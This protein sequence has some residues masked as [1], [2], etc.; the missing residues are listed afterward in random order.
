MTTIPRTHQVRSFILARRKYLTSR[1]DV[2]SADQEEDS[3][4]VTAKLAPSVLQFI[5]YHPGC[6]LTKERERYNAVQLGL[7]YCPRKDKEHERTIEYVI[8]LPPRILLL[9]STRRQEDEGFSYSVALMSR[10]VTTFL[11]G[12]CIKSSWTMHHPTNLL[13]QQQTKLAPSGS[14]QVHSIQISSG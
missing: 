9:L 12:R 3:S 11:C 6:R 1:V 10:Q 7:Q 5:L 4:W 13:P 8:L 2:Y 14:E